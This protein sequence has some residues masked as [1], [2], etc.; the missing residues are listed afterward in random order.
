MGQEGPA[1]HGMVVGIGKRPMFLY[2]KVERNGK[3]MRMTERH[4]DEEACEFLG[5]IEPDDP[6]M[7]A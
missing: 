6:V 2:G 7:T 4:E 1:G 3:D 5:D